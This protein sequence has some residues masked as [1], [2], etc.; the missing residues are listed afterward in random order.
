MPIAWSEHSAAASGGT[1]MMGRELERRIDPGLLA[2]TQVFMSRVEGELDPTKVRVLWIHD[3]AEDPMYSH[4]S[5][6]GWR[7]F[8]KLVFVSYWQMNGFVRR[9]GIPYSRCCVIRNAVEPSDPAG[10]GEFYRDGDPV[11]LIYT[12]TPHRGLNVLYAAFSKLS[13][14]DD[15]VELDVYSS[16]KLYGWG[17][18]DKNFQQLFDS[19]ESH[20]RIRS[21]GTVPNGELRAALDR[22]HIFAYP[23]TWPETSCRCLM[24]AMSSGLLCVHSD[25]AAL[26]ETAANWTY[27]Y[28][29]DEDQ[30]RHAGVFYQALSQAVSSV[31][32]GAGRQVG[33]KSYADL[34]HTWGFRVQEWEGLITSLLKAPRAIEDGSEFV[35]RVA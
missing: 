22:S 25:L 7:R 32:A 26:P 14:E 23:S 24:E 17:D 4:L 12:P 11:R 15:G 2:E 3:V 29:F 5:G 6:G 18:Q 10:L 35:Y 27:M 34:F 30:N 20:P 9:Y 19:I 28:H 33:Q 13:E 31:R 8:H 1:E 21:H 16:F